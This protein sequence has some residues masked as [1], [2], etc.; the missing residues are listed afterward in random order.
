[1]SRR[2]WMTGL[3]VL[4]L[5]AGPLT[6]CAEQP[7]IIEPDPVGVLPPV[8]QPEQL[9]RIEDSLGAEIEASEASLDPAKLESRFGGAALAM[10]TAE[11]AIK[12]AYEDFKI[13][14]LGTI[15]KGLNQQPAVVAQSKTWPRSVVVSAT[16]DQQ[17]DQQ[18]PGQQ[19]L[20][21]LTQS[22][23][24]SDYKL[25]AYGRLLAN[26]P[27]T[28]DPLTG[29]PVV[30]LDQPGEMNMSPLAALSAYAN[31]KEDPFGE[32]APN[33]TT[34]MVGEG[35]N[36]TDPARAA[37]TATKAA[38]S[39]NLEKV[40]G[41][42]SSSSGPVEGSVMALGTANN[43]AIVFGQ[44]L[45]VIDVAITLEEGGKYEL[46]DLYLGLGVSEATKAIHLEYL[47]TIV[48]YIPPAGL[49][50]LVQ[51]LATSQVPVRAEVE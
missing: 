12:S 47:Q 9:T 3:A 32:E 26:P 38:F 23:A 17:D 36:D 11:F 29:S 16:S 33:F 50:E 6:G 46:G 37:W 20:Y 22:D 49:G 10:R 5:L 44:V 48:L 45:S 39:E 28:A 18:G 24:R 13:N 34:A 31:A 14:E 43:G 7:P 4:A 15:F 21:Q 2:C 8:I 30:E 19:F 42:M 51:P 25:V 35:A 1:M 41:S 27:K 40:N